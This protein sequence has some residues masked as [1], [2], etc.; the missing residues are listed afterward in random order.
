MDSARPNRPPSPTKP[1]T[2]SGQCSALSA[3]HG[4]PACGRPAAHR[5]RAPGPRVPSRTESAPSRYLGRPHG[6]LGPA[7]GIPG[8]LGPGR[9]QQVWAG[10]PVPAR[11]VRASPGARGA[12]GPAGPSWASFISSPAE[13]ASA[14]AN[15]VASPLPAHSETPQLRWRTLRPVGEVGAAGRRPGWLGGRVRGAWRPP[16]APARPPRPGREATS[17]AAE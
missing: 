2:P 14:G 1:S 4:G 13:R 10:P 3:F 6:L 11:R 9:V 7:V 15:N 8:S 12:P 5:P 17:P 16:P